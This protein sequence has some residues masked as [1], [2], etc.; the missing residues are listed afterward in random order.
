MS[1]TL[2]LS[3]L[4]DEVGLDEEELIRLSLFDSVSPGRS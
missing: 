3:V 1:N 4:C 2:K